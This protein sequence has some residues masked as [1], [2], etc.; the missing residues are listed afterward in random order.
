M[1]S[2][3]DL[4]KQLSE[5]RKKFIQAVEAFRPQLHKYCSRM[6]GSILD[7]EDLVQETLAQAFY[8]LSIMHQ[9]V[10]LKPWL[11][12]IAHNKCI[13]FLR[14]KQRGNL[15]LFEIEMDHDPHKEVERK[16]LTEEAISILVNNLPP[17]ERAC[18]ILKDV[19]DYS[20]E[21]ISLILE[22]PLTAVKSALHRGR[23]KLNSSKPVNNT[24]TTSDQN[25]LKYYVKLINE[26]DWE[27][28]KKLVADDA[29][30]EVVGA[31]HGLGKDKVSGSYFHNWSI[32][33][34]EWK[35]E[36]TNIWSE[37]CLVTKSRVGA[38]WESRSLIRIGFQDS[39]VK[40]ISDYYFSPYIFDNLKI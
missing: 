16:E 19:L 20:L 22:S 32:D 21:E 38:K 12:K 34:D 10:S 17:K 40:H 33:P 23:E 7:G 13:D 1:D 37:T 30:Y 24:T 25:L 35:V 3:N 27:N 14:S 11:F 26:R 15:Q 2:I 36:I 18:L 8:K 39:K 31:C 4:E 5:A 6:T 9:D 29:S 28:L